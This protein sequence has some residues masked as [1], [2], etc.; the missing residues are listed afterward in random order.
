MSRMSNFYKERFIRSGI[1]VRRQKK[2][3]LVFKNKYR[4]KYNKNNK[5]SFNF[6]IRY[7]S[8][9]TKIRENV[10]SDLYTRRWDG[11]RRIFF[12][13]NLRKMLKTSR[14]VTG[15]FFGFYFFHEKRITKFIVSYKNRNFKKY[16]EMVFLRISS[17][18]FMSK[19]TYNSYDIKFFIDSNLV[20]VNGLTLK[21]VN[22]ITSK[23][24]I[25]S[26]KI[27]W[28]IYQ[29]IIFNNFKSLFSRDYN[30]F[31]RG[32][33]FL[34]DRNRYLFDNYKYSNR[35]DSF[36]YYE[37]DF[38]TMT[39]FV[40]YDYYFIYNTKLNFFQRNVPLCAITSLNWKYLN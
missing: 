38:K 33:K 36:K 26:I 7:L 23:F 24:D 2:N 5:R 21:N 28:K 8:H 34:D 19:I 25:I 12:K 27:S 9:K 18:L 11:L 3:L 1:F 6:N 40:I 31:R 20:Y 30:G 14:K 10:F 22:Y 13:H 35:I 29:Y 17:L 16:I 39:I 4:R 32:I 37:T 15:K